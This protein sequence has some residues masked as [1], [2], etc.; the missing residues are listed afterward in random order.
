MGRTYRTDKVSLGM[1]QLYV[2]LSSLYGGKC[3]G[4]ENLRRNT[5]I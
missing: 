5:Y 2:I 4:R 1:L 3:D